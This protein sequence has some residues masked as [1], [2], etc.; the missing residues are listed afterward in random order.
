MTKSTHPPHGNT[1]AF[2]RAMALCARRPLV[3]LALYVAAVSLVFLIFPSLDLWASGMFYNERAGFWA[4]HE[5]FLSQVR[6]LGPHLVMWVAVTMVAVVL[7]KLILPDRPPVLPLRIP[8]F[9][10]STLILGPGILVNAI[11]KDN[12]GRPRPRSVEDFGGDLPHQL[13]WIPTDYC[14]SNCSFVSGEASAGIWLTALAFIVP[15]AWRIGVLAFVLPLCLVLSVNRVAFGGHFLSDTMISW[16]LTLMVIVGV[17]KLLYTSRF[18]PTDEALDRALSAAGLAV[19]KPVV[20]ALT[21]GR[22]AA[23]RFWKMFSDPA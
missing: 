20:R 16:G 2:R 6:H 13:V 21:S 8:V 14:E 18:Q 12:W 1:T 7:L 4:Q 5:P 17:Y 11:L 22:R 9:L 19:R 3:L 23:G 15:A 10:T